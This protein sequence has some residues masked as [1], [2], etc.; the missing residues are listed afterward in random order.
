MSQKKQIKK[1][2]YR[3]APSLLL[4]ILYP[5]YENKDMD[6]ADRTAQSII[7]D[8]DIY[9]D[10]SDT[11]VKTVNFYPTETSNGKYRNTIYVNA[12]CRKFAFDLSGSAMK[13]FRLTGY[14]ID[15]EERQ[16]KFLDG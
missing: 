3:R 14:R 13:Y 1:S 8:V 6:S 11:A 5:I 16:R 10:D 2:T 7:I 15:Y 9:T 4:S 12:R